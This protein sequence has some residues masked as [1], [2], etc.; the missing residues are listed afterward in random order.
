MVQPDIGDGQGDD[1]RELPGPPCSWGSLRCQTRLTSQSTCGGALL[2]A[3]V[4]LLVV[5]I[6]TGFEVGV[7]AAIDDLDHPL[8][9]LE[10]HLLLI[11]ALMDNLLLA[12]PLVR[13]HAVAARLLLM[14]V[15]VSFL[16][17]RHSSALWHLE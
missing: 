4:Q 15:S 13:R 5:L 7:R 2:L 12:C 10:L 11:V 6:I 14:E 16:I 8:G 9:V 1:Q 17:S 3:W